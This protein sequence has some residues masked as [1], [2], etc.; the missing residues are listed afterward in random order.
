M[1]N[2]DRQPELYCTNEMVGESDEFE[3]FWQKVTQGTFLWNYFKI[4]LSV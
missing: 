4:I 2:L 1:I 3:Q